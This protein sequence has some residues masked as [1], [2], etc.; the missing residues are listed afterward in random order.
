MGQSCCSDKSNKDAHLEPGKVPLSQRE[1]ENAK[2]LEHAKNSEGKII[3]LQ[4]QEM[5]PYLGGF[6]F[7]S[8]F[9]N[10]II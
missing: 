8:I 9:I 2:L 10:N 1:R 4:A 6:R 5:E 3:K 7:F